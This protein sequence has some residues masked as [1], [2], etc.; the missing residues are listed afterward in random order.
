MPTSNPAAQAR[1]A[2]RGL[3]PCPEGAHTL[4]L[5]C[6]V[7]RAGQVVRRLHLCRCCGRLAAE[8]A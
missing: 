2:R 1:L 8:G 3:R 4:V 5:S 7:R 6:R